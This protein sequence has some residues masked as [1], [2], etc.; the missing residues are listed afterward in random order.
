MQICQNGPLDKFMQF[1]FM[2]SNALC[3]VMYSAIKFMQYKFMQLALDSHNSYHAEICRF[4]V[5]NF[6][7][8]TQHMIGDTGCSSTCKRMQENFGRGIGRVL[9]VGRLWVWP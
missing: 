1:L 2:R 7:T 3:I 8:V 4:M 9:E 5:L 6:N